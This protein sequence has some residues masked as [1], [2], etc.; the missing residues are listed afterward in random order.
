MLSAGDEYPVHQTPEPVAMVG[1]RNFYDRFFYNGCSPDGRL[2]F[3]AA[4][5]VYPALDVID[6]AFCVSLDGVQHNLR[7]AGR[8]NG[9]RMAMAVGPLSVTVDVPLARV[10]VRVA[11]NAASPLSAEL[12]FE[13]RHF[14]IEEPRFTRRVGTRLWMD[15]TRMTQNGRWSGWIDI[16]GV[17]HAVTPDVTGTRDR[18]WGIRPVGAAD[19]QPAPAAPQ[20]FWLWTPCNLPGHSVYFHS[21][22]DAQG[23]PWNRRAV[24]FADGAGRNEGREFDAPSY[25]IQWQPGTRRVRQVVI[26]LAAE[27]RLTLTPGGRSGICAGAF[28]HE[29]AGL[30]PSGLGPWHG[31]WRLRDRL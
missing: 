21:N 26:D 5:G 15:Y 25:A 31:A 24:L 6:A 17:R 2:F 7:V 12:L 13:G 22:D 11:A 30:Y 10:R 18:S 3:A 16:A 19:L 9:A 4:L 20:F 8:L 23:M 1:D 28:L 27:T 29:R 14:P